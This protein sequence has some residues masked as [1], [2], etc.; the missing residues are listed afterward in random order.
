MDVYLACQ[1]M[2]YLVTVGLLLTTAEYLFLLREF[3][4][5]GLYSWNII[6]EH[7]YWMPRLVGTIPQAIVGRHFVTIVLS[8]RLGLLAALPF[9]ADFKT[10]TLLPWL[11]LGVL[12]TDGYLTTRCCIYGAD[13]A[14][15]MGRTILCVLC[16]CSF[17]PKTEILSLGL[18]FVAAQSCLAYFVAGV[19]KVIGKEWRR[20]T[21]CA[22]I[23][24]TR[25]YGTSLLAR[26]FSLSPALS[27]IASWSVIV[28]ECS[29]PL[30][31]LGSFYIT[32][33]YIILGLTFHIFNALVMGLNSFFWAFAATYPAVYFVSCQIIETADSGVITKP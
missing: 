22:A 24:N 2:L 15:Q 5:D 1:L 19:A 3:E 8:L 10:P 4:N 31:L 6:R 17:L 23:F 18:V 7:Y 30:A 26:V 11:L 16:I 28:F 29:F 12:A 27:F 14:D 21:A 33:I 25:S 20:G 13:G 9:F 32:T